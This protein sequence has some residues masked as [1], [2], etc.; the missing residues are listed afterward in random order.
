MT[1]HVQLDAILTHIAGSFT[2]RSRLDCGLRATWTNDV[3]SFHAC[4]TTGSLVVPNICIIIIITLITKLTAHKIKLLL[5]L[6]ITT[7]TQ[8]ILPLW[9]QLL[10]SL[11]FYYYNYYCF[12]FH[13]LLLL[14]EGWVVN[15]NSH[16]SNAPNILSGGPSIRAST[17]PA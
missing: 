12:F 3:H 13:A 15:K 5:L 8:L 11:I 6:L 10:P 9:W 17:D 16:S 14:N 1:M 4:T 7:T 2:V